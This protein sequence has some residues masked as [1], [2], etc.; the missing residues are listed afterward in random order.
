VTNADA[1]KPDI[2]YALI[3]GTIVKVHRHAIGA[4]GGLTIRPSTN[5]VQGM[6]CTELSMFVTA[7]TRIAR[8]LLGPYEL[9]IVLPTFNEVE[10]VEPN[11][12]KIDAA[13][14]NVAWEVVFVD[15]DSKD[16]TPRAVMAAAK[17]RPNVRIVRRV[18]RRGL[19]SAVVEGALTSMAPYIAVMDA[20]MQHDETMLKDMLSDLRAGAT[21]LIVGTRYTAGGGVGEW[22]RKRLAASRIATKIAQ[23]V[24]RT[25]LSDPMSGFFMMTREAFESVVSRLSGQGFKILLDI[26]ASSE[27]P[28]RVAEKAYEFKPRQ[29]GESKF[30]SFVA[31]EYLMLLID[32]TF[33]H[34]VPTRFILFAV[35][36][37]FGLSV[38]MAILAICFQ[39]LGTGFAAS[40]STATGVAM[41]FNFFVNNFLTYH[42][43]RLKGLKQ[44]F[45][46]LLSFCAVC[47]LGAITNVGIANYMFI[48]L[49][50][51]W[52]SGVAGVIVGAV[53]N[54][55]ATSVF[56][57][58]VAK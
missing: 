38:H 54:Y 37:G 46:G 2:D 15:D 25:K 33:G 39:V 7:E 47:S 42:D 13:L 22:S 17:K 48:N 32:K 23:I 10:N 16:G 57:W 21:D 8:A 14:P 58:R 20:D 51:W 29:F 41:T 27:R 4:K 55:A 1:D 40:Q 30:D 11:L 5:R 9:T 31:I 6:F 45:I 49:Y 53:W 56:T 19:S 43:R 12:K 44:L 35:V 52:L 26:V 18:G 34:L 3:D 50:S 24:T 36:G 28:L